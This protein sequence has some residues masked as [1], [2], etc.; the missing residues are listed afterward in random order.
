MTITQ[1]KV[2]TVPVSDQDAAKAFY[3][4]TLGFQVLAD[5]SDGPMRWLQVAP[6]GA[7]TSIVLAALPGAT[8]GGMRG[9]MLES[10]DLDADCATLREAGVAVDGPDRL[11]WGRQATFADPDGN[12]IVLTEKW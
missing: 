3:A 1:V 2:L 9:L 7:A 5:N 4:G 12:E 10:S 6:E 11:P 8:P